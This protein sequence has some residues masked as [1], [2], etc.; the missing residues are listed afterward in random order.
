MIPKFS[1]QVLG[2]PTDP[3]DK[4]REMVEPCADLLAK[5]TNIIGASAITIGVGT[6][7][8]KHPQ[9]ISRTT[10]IML[11]QASSSVKSM[12][13]LIRSGHLMGLRDCLVISRGVLETL[14]NAGFILASGEEEANKAE[15]HAVYKFV[16]DVERLR[17][18]KE[19]KVR[20]EFLKIFPLPELV[21][22]SSYEQLEEEF[23][24]RSGI[25][26]P[27]TSVSFRDRIK[28]IE[29]EFH[30]AGWLMEQA[31]FICYRHASEI[32]HGTFF[33][34]MHFLGKGGVAAPD[35]TFEENAFPSFEAYLINSL[36][37]IVFGTAGL[38]IILLEKYDIKGAQN[39]HNELLQSLAQQSFMSGLIDEEHIQK[40]MI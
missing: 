40:L 2:M 19:Q 14:V 10:A 35:A 13:L 22:N 18:Y 1:H 34:C 17:N 15:R 9:N 30:D 11:Q 31:S 25:D 3:E 20:A 28:F 24:Q 39:F 4:Y 36:G 12:E 5:A 23:S 27:W 21:K 38:M 32:T 8:R 29:Q 7:F 26:K 6:N 37:A 33:G 16:K